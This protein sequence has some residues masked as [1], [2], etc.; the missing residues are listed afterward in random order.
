MTLALVASLLSCDQIKSCW[1]L[2][3]RWIWR[4]NNLITPQGGCPEWNQWPIFESLPQCECAITHNICS[5]SCPICQYLSNIWEFTWG[6]MCDH[7][8]W[9]SFVQRSGHPPVRQISKQKS[10]AIVIRSKVQF[11]SQ[12]KGLKTSAKGPNVRR[13][14]GSSKLSSMWTVKIDHSITIR[15]AKHL[16]LW[17]VCF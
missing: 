16:G 17:Y 7:P 11:L 10:L 13:R 15:W 5:N 2:E 8:H 3:R 9:H 6:W 14:R 4:Q 12:N 1:G